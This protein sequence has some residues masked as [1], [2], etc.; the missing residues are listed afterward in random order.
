MAVCALAFRSVACSASGPHYRQ[1]VFRC[2]LCELGHVS[3]K[4]GLAPSCVCVG[5]CRR[6]SVTSRTICVERTRKLRTIVASVVHSY[7]YAPFAF[8][9]PH[10][11][12][13]HGMFSS[14]FRRNHI[15][16]RLPQHIEK[17]VPV[18]GPAAAIIRLALVFKASP[19]HAH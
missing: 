18:V 11:C 13:T 15:F 7:Q 19:I 1:Y 16:G 5:E 6:A 8:A 17:I 10:N 12:A 3:N 2:R 14:R 4:G 9:S